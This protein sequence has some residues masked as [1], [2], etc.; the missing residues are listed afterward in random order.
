MRYCKIRLVLRRLHEDRTLIQV[1]VS[2]SLWQSRIIPFDSLIMETQKID[3]DLFN[4][5]DY[6][7]SPFV[8]DVKCL[9]NSVCHLEKVSPQK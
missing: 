7:P 4:K 5:F 2:G 1:W 6:F 9:V 3:R 8:P